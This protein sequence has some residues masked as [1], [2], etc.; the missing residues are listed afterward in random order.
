M[1]RRRVLLSHFIAITTPKPTVIHGSQFLTI[2]SGTPTPKRKVEV[3]FHYLLQFPNQKAE[4]IIIHFRT[5]ASNLKAEI[6]FTI[7]FGTST[8]RSKRGRFGVGTFIL[9]HE[10]KC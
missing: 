10:S 6:I 8:L 1:A 3:E 4:D 2:H 9:E 7:H 5:S